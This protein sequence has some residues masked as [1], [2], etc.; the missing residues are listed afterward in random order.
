M[1]LD[2]AVEMGFVFTV[3]YIA[4]VVTKYLF[5]IK[6][7]LREAPAVRESSR[8]S[9]H[10]VTQ[11]WRGIPAK[12]HPLELLAAIDPVTVPHRAVAGV[13]PAILITSD[14][15]RTRLIDRSIRAGRFGSSDEL[16][17]VDCDLLGHPELLLKLRDSV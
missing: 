14:R 2:A 17:A 16:R 8:M 7:R 11:C 1:F 3:F 15:H 9:G 13:M 6:D 12:Y 10:P 5:E 4:R